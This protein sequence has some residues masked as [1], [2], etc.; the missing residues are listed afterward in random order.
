MKFTLREF[1]KI[2]VGNLVKKLKQ[3][4]REL[5]DDQVLQAITLSAPTASGKTVMMTSLIE[6][7]LLG[8]G[9]LEEYDTDF[10]IEKDAV[11]LWLS[12]S[13]Q[14]NRQSLEKMS[15]AASRELVGL[16][17][18]VEATF[19]EEYFKPGKIYFLNSQKLSVAG[20]LTRK[21]NDREYSIWETVNNTINR[22]KSRF[23]VIIDEAH[24]GMRRTAAEQNQA[25]SIIQKFIIGVQGEVKPSP[26]VIGVSAT[27]ERFDTLLS[28]A[29][30]TRRSVNIPADDARSAGLI[31]DFILMCHK[32]VDQPTEWTLLAAACKEYVRISN[33]WEMYC[34][35][36]K[37]KNIVRPVLVIQVQDSSKDSE[38]SES[39]TPL[40]KLV[41]VVKQNIAGITSINF[42]HCLES[43]KLLNTAGMDIRYVEPHRIEHD[44]SVRVVIFKMALTTGW[45]CP[46]AEVMMSFRNAEDSTY[47]AQLV[48]R[49]V[50][51]PLARRMEGN[52]LLNSVMLFLPF[53]NRE[54]V[55]VVVDKLQGDGGETKG[56]DAGNQDEFQ[57]LEVARDKKALLEF[58]EALPTYTSQEGKK[59]TDIRRALRFAFE[60]SCD[61]WED[62]TRTIKKNLQNTLLKMGTERAKDKAFSERVHSLSKVNY[63]MLKVENGVLKPD[64]QGEQRSLTVTEQD[65]DTVFSRSFS[66]LTEELSRAYVASR[67]DPNDPESVY[68]RFKLELFLLSQDESLVNE[69]EK[70]A[71]RS[72][73]KIYEEKKPE[74]NKLPIERQ[75]AY[76]RLIQ[77]SRHFQATQPSIP[78]PLRLKTDKG[79]IKL[80]DHLFVDNTGH[81][82]AYLNDWETKVFEAAKKEKG[83]AG[84][85][86]N[87]PRKPWSIAYK[88]SANGEDTPGYPDFIVF[89]KNSNDIVVDLLEPHHG[90]DSLAKAHG[91]CAFAAEF[92]EK[93]GRI[94]WIKIEGNQLKRLNLNSPSVRKQVL[95]TKIDQAL[96]DLFK[97]VGSSE[98]IVTS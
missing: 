54:Q 40:S 50:R 36:N 84:W 19:D 66:T 58:Y 29:S 38:E 4:K 73:E 20:L 12:D 69:V 5:D 14:L 37:E 89:R 10:E 68:W 92:G 22:Q 6:R 47:I 79:A 24:R 3:A 78:T 44:E 52:D 74:I 88:Y 26:I 61:G 11:F 93:F 81:F 71:Q 62:D 35:D 98:N 7:V 46:R 96:D 32:D 21:G 30:R 49:I 9:G 75:G 60:L 43:G 91:L 13:P 34:T 2:A 45:D 83:F 16:L 67:F 85:V 70:E 42:A 65:V 48:G 25:Q 1:Q 72:I 94:D 28:G 59:V 41:E 31:K 17:E 87:Y 53:F 33:E 15:M 57:T 18:P 77:S 27:P 95:A 86:R 76:K 82:K 80:P 97:M 51:T 63:R 55:Q 23:Y 39:R 56:A 8:K 64:D 90:A